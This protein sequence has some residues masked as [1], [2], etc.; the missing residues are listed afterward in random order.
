MVEDTFDKYIMEFKNVCPDNLCDEIVN[1]F[2]SN[3][4]KKE[5]GMTTNASGSGNIVSELKRTTDAHFDMNIPYQ[6]KISCIIIYILTNGKFKYIETC[7]TKNLD[8]KISEQNPYMFTIDI[9]QSY[10]INCI[11]SSPR[12]QKYGEGDYFN[13]HTDY[14]VTQRRFLAYILYLNDVD[15]DSG[16]ETVFISGKRIRPEKG[17]LLV[18]PASL[19]YIHKGETIKKGSKYIITSFSML[20]DVPNF[21]LE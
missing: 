3:N 13:W 18:F 4:C 20:P 6:Y 21:S 5:A 10:L 14:A 17:K 7:K 11:E 8:K 16:G 19:N 1:W 15:S 2:E 12:I 9:I